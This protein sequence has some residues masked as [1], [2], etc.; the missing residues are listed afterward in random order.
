VGLP[1]EASCRTFAIVRG[2]FGICF[3]Q[4]TVLSLPLGNDPKRGFVPRRLNVRLIPGGREA[5]AR[6]GPVGSVHDAELLVPAEASESLMTIVLLKRV[7]CEY[8]RFLYRISLGL[9]RVRSELGHQAI[10]LLL[11]RAALLRFRTPWYSEGS[12]WAEVGWDIERGLLVARQ[13]RGRGSLRIRIQQL[14]HDEWRNGNAR[15]LIRM[16]VEGYYPRIRGGGWFRPTGAW[17]YGQTQARIHRL[18]F[19]QF[20]RSLAG[21]ELTPSG[22]EASLPAT[23]RS[24]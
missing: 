6:R 16:E 9:L 15:L 3:N 7:A 5:V 24:S 22:S 18:V 20:L 21:L 17:L 23:Q 12:D 1:P 11:P 4:L 10:V 2:N 8:R 14:A 19:R 13:G